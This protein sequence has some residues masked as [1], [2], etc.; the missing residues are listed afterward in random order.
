MKL[1]YIAEIDSTNTELMRRALRGGARAV[2]GVAL[3]A[4]HQSAGRGQRG[5][6]WRDSVTEPGASLLLS[7]GWECARTV[8][9]DG[10]SLSLGLALLDTLAPLVAEPEALAVKW[11]NDLLYGSGK[12]GGILVETVNP[13]DA[14]ATRALVVGSGLNL[15]AVPTL[16]A[17]STGRAL[18]VRALF[19]DA[20]PGTARAVRAKVLDRLLPALAACL[21]R[22][23]QRGFA[24][25]REAFEARMAW[26]GQSVEFVRP[27]GETI[28]GRIDGVA[29]DGALS[30]IAQGQRLTLHSGELRKVRP[31]A[32]AIS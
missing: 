26:R 28:C 15:T 24:A 27:T 2:H 16:G 11:P 32:L 30:L 5:R 13:I 17:E 6:V 18:P 21:E 10:L 9:L 4:D 20:A 8:P 7:V 1:E 29:A 3:V 31:A 19:P 25:D 12:C 22:F 14:S 23:E